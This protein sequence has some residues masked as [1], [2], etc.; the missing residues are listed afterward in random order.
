MYNPLI[1]IAAS[2]V[3]A[4]VS[5]AERS[6]FDMELS[7]FEIWMGVPHTTVEGLP[8]GTYQSDKVTQGTPIGLADPK[9]VFTMVEEDGVPVLKVSGEI[10]G[11]LTSHDEF[12]NYH[13]SVYAKWG[14]KKWEPR[15]EK[16]R[17]SGLLYHCYGKHGSFWK[18]WKSS[19]EL[20][21]QETDLGDFIPLAGP[22]AEVRGIFS[23]K[24]GLY[25]PNSEE[26][27]GGYVS[28][29]P[30]VDAPHG[31]WNHIE[32]YAIGNDSVHVVNGSIVMVVENAV[33]PDGTPLTHGQIQLQSEA[34]ELYYKELTI[35]PIKDFPTFIKEGVQFKK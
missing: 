19:L 18:V 21:V 23:D 2:V 28:A 27:G 31:E 7:E 32:L 25:D 14:D 3:V 6:L 35:T 13:L 29:N 10:Y 30:E 9:Q 8:E 5:H 12:E 22:K 16:L 20:Q 24:R 15:L 34:A 11:G 33:K 4:H 17:D 26:F 1:F